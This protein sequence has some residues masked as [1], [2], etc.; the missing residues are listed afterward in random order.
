[1]KIFNLVFIPILLFFSCASQ[2]AIALKESQKKVNELKTLL[3]LSDQQVEK[4]TSIETNYLKDF[5]KL[6]YS[7][8]YNSKLKALK[9]KR[10]ASIKEL[11]ARDQFIKFDLLENNRIKQ[12]P[13]QVNQ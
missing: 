13:I 10:I 8:Q 2:N 11:L 3:A 1:M 6:E 4:L 5:Q 9:D 7:L 12:V